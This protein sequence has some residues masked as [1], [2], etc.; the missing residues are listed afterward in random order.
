MEEEVLEALPW[1]KS[2]IGM[3]RCEGMVFKT[4]HLVQSI[5]YRGILSSAGY[6]LFYLKNCQPGA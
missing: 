1:A 4:I 2:I 6:Y 3:L 5:E